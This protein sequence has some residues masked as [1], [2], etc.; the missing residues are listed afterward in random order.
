MAPVSDNSAAPADKTK[1]WSK[2]VNNRATAAAVE[3]A[4]QKS[5]AYKTIYRKKE[6]GLFSG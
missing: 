2:I 1:I 5:Q 4:W 3:W 6:I